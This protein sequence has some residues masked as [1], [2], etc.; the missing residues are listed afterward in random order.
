[1][2][3]GNIESIVWANAAFSGTIL[4]ISLLF[5]MDIKIQRLMPFFRTLNA[6]GSA[7]RG[8]TLVELLVVIAIIGLLA[9]VVLTSLSSARRKS[10][11]AKRLADMKQLATALELYFNDFSGYPAASG[12]APSVPAGLAPS[13]IGI[14]PTAPQP[15]DGC[16]GLAA[17]NYYNYT[18]STAPA[19]TYAYTFCLSATTGGYSAGSHSLSPTGIQ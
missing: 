10:R 15:Y 3:K 8:F 7:N 17:S 12:T 16:N 13:Y 6:G 14:F 2:E 1:M 9:S 19:T 18:P 5:C 11:D 4:V